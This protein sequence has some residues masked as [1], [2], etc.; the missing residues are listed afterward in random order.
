MLAPSSCELVSFD[1]HFSSVLQM[2]PNCFPLV[3]VVDLY[4]PKPLPIVGLIVGP[5]LD[6][7]HKLGIYHSKPLGK[8]AC[9]QDEKKDTTSGIPPR[10]PTCFRPWLPQSIGPR[11]GISYC[12]HIKPHVSSLLP[13]AKTTRSGWWQLGVRSYMWWCR[14][15]C[16]ALR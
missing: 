3:F 4:Y 15:P 9:T 8:P 7:V 5:T 1:L 10:P 6:P 2:P 14:I 12:C 11:F 13:L 16:K